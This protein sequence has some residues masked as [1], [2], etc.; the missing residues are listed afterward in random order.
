MADAFAPL[1]LDPRDDAPAKPLI[2]GAGPAGVSAALWLRDAGCP[3]HWLDAAGVGGTLRRI[4]HP[5][6]N[7]PGQ[8]LE[9]G[10]ALALAMERQ[11][12]ALGM[13]LWAPAIVTGVDLSRQRADIEALASGAPTSLPFSHVVFATG[14]RPRLPTQ[15]TIGVDPRAALDRALFLSTHLWAARFA[16]LP[17]AVLGGGD[18]AL[19]GALVLARHGASAVHIIHRSDT[20]RARPSFISEA[21]QRPQV[22]LHLSARVA[23]LCLSAGGDAEAIDIETPQGLQRLSARAVFVKLGV[24]PSLPALAPPD[25]LARDGAGYIL[26]DSDRRASHPRAFAVGD[27][28]RPRLQAICTAFTDGALA[29][30]A[31]TADLRRADSAQRTG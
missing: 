1:D 22:H 26:T 2:I 15:A 4:H 3:F 27:L 11:R 12:A 23:G 8:R 29:A 20:L 6:D 10:D 24:E 31:I 17:V 19:E 18:G 7:L 28:C 16:G 5:I 21:Q 13:R 14:T 9:S 30:A 25:T